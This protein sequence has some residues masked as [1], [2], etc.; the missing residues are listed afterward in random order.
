MCVHTFTPAKSR[1]PMTI[2]RN[3]LQAVLERQARDPA[4]VVQVTPS[5]A[6]I[7]ADAPRSPRFHRPSREGRRLIA[8]HFD[9]KVAKQLKLLA[10][11][12]ETT[13]QGLLEEALELLFVKKGRGTIKRV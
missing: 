7:E 12:E 1:T 8:G 3:S 10:A 11:E 9:P 4:E 6:E 2:P 5:Q 13:V